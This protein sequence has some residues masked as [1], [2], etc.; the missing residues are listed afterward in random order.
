[1][2]QVEEATRRRL[3]ELKERHQREIAKINQEHDAEISEI[4]RQ[5]EVA[6][7]GIEA[8]LRDSILGGDIGG[9]DGAAD[10]EIK[11]KGSSRRCM[12]LNIAIRIFEQTF[13]SVCILTVL[14]FICCGIFR[15]G[16]GGE[17]QASAGGDTASAG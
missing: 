9:A 4:R 3:A 10:A 12:S 2:L 15:P 7:G 16:Q 5:H 8:Q 6:K 1:L 14:T 13:M 11:G 17:G